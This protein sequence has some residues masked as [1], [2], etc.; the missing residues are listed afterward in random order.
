MPT[1]VR[2][3]GRVL[4]L[5]PFHL[6]HESAASDPSKVAMTPAELQLFSQLPAY[7]TALSEMPDD[8]VPV[9]LAHGFIDGVP[10]TGR[11]RKK[12]TSVI[13]WSWVPAQ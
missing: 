11:A 9:V 1:H 4:R 13:V 3:R 5:H 2:K 6:P 10:V 8:D 12:Q 7:K